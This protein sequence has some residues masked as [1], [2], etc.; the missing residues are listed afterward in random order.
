[1]TPQLESLKRQKDPKRAFRARLV[2]THCNHIECENSRFPV[3]FSCIA[4]LNIVTKRVF[5]RSSRHFWNPCPD[6]MLPLPRLLTPRQVTK[7]NACHENR[8]CSNAKRQ[9]QRM[10]QSAINKSMVFAMKSA[11]STSSCN[12]VVSAAQ[13]GEASCS[14][15][16]ANGC[17]RSSNAGRTRLYLDS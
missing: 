2:L 14:A 15:L 17:G 1:M 8:Q 4:I 3:S 7:C 10:S 5:L 9:S 16:I 12:H 13:R 6:K 11:S